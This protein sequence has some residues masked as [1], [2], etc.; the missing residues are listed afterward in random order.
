MPF[1]YVFQKK[2]KKQKYPFF[3]FDKTYNFYFS[4]KENSLFLPKKKGKIVYPNEV[5]LIQLNHLLLLFI[6]Y[7][8]FGGENVDHLL[9]RRQ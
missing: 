8:F 4:K 7:H 3:L 5:K 2:Q 6:Y 9:L 1:F